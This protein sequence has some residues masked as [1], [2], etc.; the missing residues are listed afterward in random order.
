[1][2]DN[3]S[4]S[5]S[6]SPQAKGDATRAAQD[7]DI[8]VGSCFP[9]DGRLVGTDAIFTSP[10]VVPH[11]ASDTAPNPHKRM[12]VPTPSGELS[13]GGVTVQRGPV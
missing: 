7:H 6:S 1:M 2:W 11:H 12:G 8:I 4:T 9:E 13:M 5:A 3:W 10:N